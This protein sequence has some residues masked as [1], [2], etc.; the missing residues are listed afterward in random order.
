M[1]SSAPVETKTNFSDKQNLSKEQA[2]ACSDV[3][4]VETPTETVKYVN[5]IKSAI[6][7]SNNINSINIETESVSNVEHGKAN[8]SGDI[9]IDKLAGRISGI[10]S[11]NGNKEQYEVIVEDIS[12][13]EKSGRAESEI[14]SNAQTKYTHV[15]GNSV[16]SFIEKSVEVPHE[17]SLS[18]NSRQKRQSGFNGNNET[19]RSNKSITEEKI[20][21][22]EKIV[23]DDAYPETSKDVGNDV[24]ESLKLNND[25]T[26]LKVLDDKTADGRGSYQA[27]SS[28][29]IEVTDEKKS[30]LEYM[31]VEDISPPLSMALDTFDSTNINETVGNSS[32]TGVDK[33]LSCDRS[34]VDAFPSDFKMKSGTYQNIFTLLENDM[35]E[36]TVGSIPV[37]EAGDSNLASLN[38]KDNSETS[39]AGQDDTVLHVPDLVDKESKDL[40]LHLEENNDGCRETPHN[41]MGKEDEN[42]KVNSADR[43]GTSAR[44]AS[45]DYH[46]DGEK[47]D[48]RSESPKNEGIEQSDSEIKDNTVSS[49]VVHQAKPGSNDSPSSIESIT[50]TVNG[51]GQMEQQNGRHLDE[52]GK[53]KG[54]HLDEEGKED[55][56][57]SPSREAGKI[58]N[59]PLCEK[60]NNLGSDQVRH[61][62]GCIV[63]EAG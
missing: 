41:G 7:T 44:I 14:E 13:D 36:T 15:S 29:E 51:G 26:E 48:C 8:L 10:F 55:S 24:S 59:E 17:S 54:R 1:T 27:K 38:V 28:A 52:E 25:V 31:E 2:S 32:E 40:H 30:Y 5:D 46:L 33:V 42:Y 53:Q 19:E 4:H 34:S 63:T 39:G 47:L 61:K 22:N 21:L 43:N 45:P 11:E 23:Q 58:L 62:L 20:I 6:N 3:K 18:P 49:S 9:D 35:S 60:S 56:V 57:S 16:T 37:N 12:D 50:E